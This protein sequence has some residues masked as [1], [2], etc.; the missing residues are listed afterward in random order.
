MGA[1][2]ILRRVLFV[3]LLG[4]ALFT[5]L[6]PPPDD[7]DLEFESVSM[8]EA[9]SDYYLE[10]FRI[11]QSDSLGQTEYTLEGEL[12]S[13]DP[14]RDVAD[15][16]APDLTVTHPD[17]LVWQLTARHGEMPRDGRNITLSDTVQLK[18]TLADGTKPSTM[19]TEAIQI[20]INAGRLNGDAP[21]TLQ[22][23]GWQVDAQGMTA[24]TGQGALQLIGR[25]HGRYL[26]APD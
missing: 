6:R 24:D 2:K 23:P 10:G 26:T 21:V 16:I 7:T 25:T 3:L 14:A 20:D 8:V 22:G 17:G 4:L 5:W 11:L 19:H 1:G 13:Y 9:G 18:R 15:L 12:L